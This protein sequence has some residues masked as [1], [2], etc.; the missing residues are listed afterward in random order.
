MLKIAKTY[1]H[2]RKRVATAMRYLLAQ[3]WRLRVFLRVIVWKVCE[4]DKDPDI[5]KRNG[6]AEQIR[7]RLKAVKDCEDRI[8]KSHC[9]G[10]MPQREIVNE[11][12]FY[13]K[14]IDPRPPVW[15]I[16]IPVPIPWPIPIPWPVPIPIPIP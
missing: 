13:P 6:H 10:C 12:E 8:F 9:S 1:V 16:P 4:Q 5:R 2:N 15:P 11:R 7:N 3:R 14:P